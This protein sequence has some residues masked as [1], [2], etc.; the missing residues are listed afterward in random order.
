MKQN[1]FRIQIASYNNE[2]WVEYNIASILN[3]TYENYEVT[4]VDD[5]SKDSTYNK[6]K[7]LVG[8]NSKF[9]I[10]RNET[11]NLKGLD[12]YK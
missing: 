10:I 12:L 11:K 1:K 5:C 2:Q 8:D 9:T 6:V 3:Q 7:E 4:Y